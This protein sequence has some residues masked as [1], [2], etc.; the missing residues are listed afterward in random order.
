MGPPDDGAQEVDNP[1]E[2]PCLHGSDTPSSIPDGR[3]GS[4]S[5]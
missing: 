2:Q 5:L 3:S 1:F 4:G